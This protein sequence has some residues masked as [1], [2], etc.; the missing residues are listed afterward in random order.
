MQVTK[1]KTYKFKMHCSTLINL[2]NI[3]VEVKIV[4][5]IYL[6]NQHLE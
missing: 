2:P 4:Q 5:W 6:Q 1:K 3:I